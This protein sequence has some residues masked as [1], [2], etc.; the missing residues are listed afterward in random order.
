MFE[1]TIAL[2]GTEN[3]EK[4]HLKKVL[5]LG[6]G[7]VGSYAVEAL[8]RAGI[9]TII[10]IDADYVALSNLN[11]QLMTNQNNIGLSKVDVLEER[12]KSINPDCHVIK[13]KEF[14]TTDNLNLLFNLEPDFIIDCIDTIKTKKYLIKECLKRKVKFI[15]SMGMGNKLDPTRI[16]ITDLSKTAYDKIA[17]EL[18][19]FV[20]KEHIKGK[21][22]VIFSD[23]Q[24]IKVEKVIG[25]ISF[26]PSVAG[27]IGASYVIKEI[28][29]E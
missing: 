10:I 8:V 24:P 1:R 26:V 29:K 16:K 4:L 23:E 6:V 21:I 12:I 20:K 19:N 25:S 22:P 28:I 27:L 9:G 14:I 7:G 11:R 18:R 17:K 13:I 5:V 15:S 2:I 3:V